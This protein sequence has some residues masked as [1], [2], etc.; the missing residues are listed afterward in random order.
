MEVP[1]RQEDPSSHSCSPISPQVI[2]LKREKLQGNS[3]LR[4]YLFHP[5]FRSNSGY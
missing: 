1:R 2:A 5:K 4:N 3:L